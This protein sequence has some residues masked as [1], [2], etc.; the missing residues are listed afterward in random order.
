M[1]GRTPD[2]A[3]GWAARMLLAEDARWVGDV[4]LSA[5]AD[6]QSQAYPALLLGHHFVRIV[7]EG[8]LAVVGHEVLGTR[9]GLR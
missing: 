3:R 5:A 7:Y 1:T 8:S 9:A 4:V 6:E 2:E